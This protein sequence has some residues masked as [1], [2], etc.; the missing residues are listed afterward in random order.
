M[1]GRE[2]KASAMYLSVLPLSLGIASITASP[3]WW[4][5]RPRASRRGIKPVYETRHL[6][7]LI[8]S[9]R[10]GTSDCRTSWRGV[11]VFRVAGGTFK[12]LEQARVAISSC[13]RWPQLSGLS[14]ETRSRRRI[15]VSQEDF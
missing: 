10:L 14:W 12:L 2:E 9:T 4:S 5:V 11:P 6:T 8:A 7:L 3:L 13:A 1:M 15:M